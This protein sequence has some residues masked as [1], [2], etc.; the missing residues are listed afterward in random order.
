MKYAANDFSAKADFAQQSQASA[1]S[2]RSQKITRR[3]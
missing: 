2:G 1:A 3:V